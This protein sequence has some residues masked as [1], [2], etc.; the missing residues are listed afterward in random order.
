MNRY[1]GRMNRKTNRAAWNLLSVIAVVCALCF[2]YLVYSKLH[3]NV[4]S[5]L[6]SQIDSVGDLLEAT[7]KSN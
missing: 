3:N 4:A 5:P 6:N 7:P 1:S 2:A